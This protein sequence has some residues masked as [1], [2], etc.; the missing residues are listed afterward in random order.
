MDRNR[1]TQQGT[2]VRPQTEKLIKIHIFQVRHHENKIENLPVH[3][4]KHPSGKNIYRQ[5][6]F[7]IFSVKL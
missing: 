5:A 6:G 7:I 2:A 4:H 3:P 1:K